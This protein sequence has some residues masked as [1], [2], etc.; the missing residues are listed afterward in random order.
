[1]SKPLSLESVIGWF[2][3]SPVRL[4]SPQVAMFPPNATR[5]V[6]ENIRLSCCKLKQLMGLS[7]LT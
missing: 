4:T 1:M 5:R 3:Q 2:A 6:D 7:L